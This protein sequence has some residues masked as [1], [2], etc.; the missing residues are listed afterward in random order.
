MPAVS[1]RAEPRQAVTIDPSSVRCRR[2]R[3]ERGTCCLTSGGLIA[4]RPH[5]IRGRDALAAAADADPLLDEFFPRRGP[6]EFCGAPG[7]DGGRLGARHRAVD[8]VAGLLAA[9]EPPEVVADE[10]ECPMGAVRAVISWMAKYP[11]AWL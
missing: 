5:E 4:R 11:G 2:C 10:L 1:D 7:L 8:A 6:C 9:G 3:M